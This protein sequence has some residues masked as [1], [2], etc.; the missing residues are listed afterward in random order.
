MQAVVLAGGLGTRLLPITRTVPKAMVPICGRPFLEYQLELLRSHGITDIILCVGYLGDRI[1]THFGDGSRVGLRIRYGDERD[2]LLG[3]AGALKNVEP[4]LRDE[5]FVTYGD[6]YLR[7]DYRRVMGYF[8]Q[9][10]GMGLMVVYRNRDRYD[11]SNVAI[12]GPFVVAYDK[13]RTLPGMEHIDFGASVLRKEALQQV[14]PGVQASLED[15]YTGLIAR[16][17]LLAYIT[18]RRFYEI[19]SPRG[20]LEFEALVRAGRIGPPTHAQRHP[21]AEAEALRR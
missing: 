12:K 16:Q 11:R 21:V 2:H 13:R 1:K 5:F 7:L 14:P 20:L 17:H 3:T 4:Y 15:L 10:S 9:H 8:R 18:R 6:G 19:G